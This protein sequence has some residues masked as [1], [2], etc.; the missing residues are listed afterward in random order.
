MHVFLLHLYLSQMHLSLL[1]L[2]L[3]QKYFNCA[4]VM[5]NFIYFCVVY[6]CLETCFT[7]N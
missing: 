3:L 1:I 2:S 5:T 4:T 7:K 6:F